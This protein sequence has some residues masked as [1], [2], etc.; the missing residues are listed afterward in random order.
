MNSAAE[1]R[2]L[3]EMLVETSRM[4][5]P[6]VNAKRN[7]TNDVIVAESR[8]NRLCAGGWR[9]GNKKATILGSKNLACGCGTERGARRGL[10]DS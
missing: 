2:M 10:S 8:I 6:I 9:Q 3:R 4:C 5:D 7:L 1:I